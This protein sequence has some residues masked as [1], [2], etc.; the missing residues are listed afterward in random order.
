[1]LKNVLSIY[2]YFTGVKL[3]YDVNAAIKK[4]EQQ[5]QGFFIIRQSHLHISLYCILD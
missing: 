4:T 2:A 3:R 5:A 1:M